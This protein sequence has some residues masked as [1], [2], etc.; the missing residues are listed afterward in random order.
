[1]TS[2]SVSIPN[3]SRQLARRG[4]LSNRAILLLGGVASF[5]LALLA[6]GQAVR[7]YSVTFERF[8]SIAEDS[9]AKVDAAEAALQYVADMDTR[10]AIFVATAPDNPVHWQSQAAI[11]ASFQKF[12]EEMYI[13][14]SRLANPDQANDP[15]TLDYNKV[16]YFSFDQ[17]WQHLGNLLTAQQN[18][19]NA[20][21]L[22]EYIIADNYLQN[23]I[24]RYLLDLEA[25]NFQAMEDTQRG[26]ATAI[27]GQIALLALVVIVLALALT[28]LSFWLRNRV[29]RV[30][31]PGID[32]AMALGWLLAL[33]M[34]FELIRTPG[35]LQQM[36]DNSYYSVSASARVLA[37][38]SQAN[39]AQSGSV[40]DPGHA[41][42]WQQAFDAD[43]NSI[44]LR[45][46]GQPGCLATS[47][48]TNGNDTI[49]PN[50]AASASQIS[51][52]NTAAI[53]GIKTL[54]AKVSYPGEAQ[55]L[56]HARQAFSDYIGINAKIRDLIKAN[57]L[58]DASRL[59]TGSNPGQSAEAFTRFSAA[60]TAERDLNRAQF[61]NV[62]QAEQ[63]GLPLHQGLFGVG[64]YILVIIGLAFGV[65]HRFR[66]L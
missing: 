45:L 9:T 47:F 57:N 41:T 30:L 2:A 42:F 32:L 62:W 29:R 39:S 58:D 54:V 48:I 25:L 33:L 16:E 11:H 7:A 19:D 37:I 34:I 66:E 44:A 60:M 46:C 35:L 17:F 55:T 3:T 65:Y 4:R 43:A 26:A 6:I 22:S 23:Q 51:P 63:S 15:E 49:A 53:G 59:A 38:A 5:V 40:I 50:V 14:R 64:G 28:V 18:G 21:A 24:N 8:R 61:N 31:T 12:R 13:V 36:V 52:D 56:E 20:T 1:M 10:A 27:N